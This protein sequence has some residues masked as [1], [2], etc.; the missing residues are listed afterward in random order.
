MRAGLMAEAQSVEH[1][2]SRMAF[3]FLLGIRE[4][5]L[6][7]SLHTIDSLSDVEVT[8]AARRHLDEDL[9]QIVVL[10]DPD[11]VASELDDGFVE[12]RPARLIDGDAGKA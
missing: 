9:L 12:L 1:V 10:G 3:N 11:A 7:D 8:G 4:G 6:G 2:A 5:S